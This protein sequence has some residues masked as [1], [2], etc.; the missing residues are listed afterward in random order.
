[1]GRSLR[2]TVRRPGLASFSFSVVA[3]KKK[4]KT[5]GPIARVAPNHLV[6]SSPELW[7]HI[8]AARSPYSRAAW[9]Y[10]AVR[11]EPG[12]D[13][14]FTEV[15]NKKHEKRRK[16][17]AAGVRALFPPAGRAICNS[18]TVVFWKG[19]SPIRVSYRRARQRAHSTHSFEVCHLRRRI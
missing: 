1:M 16:Q 4:K 12:K 8:N 3:E 13:N 6:T 10:H 7:A 9:Y 11:F 17:M 2:N 5:T 18:V 15:D 14:V 19:E